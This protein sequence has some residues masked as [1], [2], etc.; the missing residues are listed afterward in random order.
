MNIGN[1]NE[2]TILDFAREVV[3]IAGSNSEVKFV[4]P[5]DERIADDPKMRRPD[6][7]KARAI[8]GWDPKVSREEGLPKTID[9][10]RG[11]V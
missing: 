6:I 5:T 7:N 8:L 1:P 10:F 9:Y 11:R 2:V 4:Q 3:R